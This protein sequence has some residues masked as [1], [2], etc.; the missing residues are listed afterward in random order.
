LMR[1]LT[2]GTR[3]SHLS[4]EGRDSTRVRAAPVHR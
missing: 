2:C 1:S 4:L 3:M